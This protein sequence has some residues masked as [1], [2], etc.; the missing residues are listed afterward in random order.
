MARRL[1][2]LATLALAALALA[3]QFGWAPPERV[4]R[5]LAAALHVAPLLPALVLFARRRRSAPFWGAVAALLL[6]AHGVGEAYA[7]PAAR[8]AALLQSAL[9]VL[10]VFAASWDGLR[11]RWA[12]RRGV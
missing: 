6:F 5:A 7:D 11:G 10:L 8:A 12:R 4:P 2:L 9:A 1:A 3:W